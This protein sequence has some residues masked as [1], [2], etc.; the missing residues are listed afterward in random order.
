MMQLRVIGLSR[1]IACGVLYLE[2]REL[3]VKF[4]ELS[5]LQVY[6]NYILLTQCVCIVSTDHSTHKVNCICNLHLGTFQD[7]K[8]IGKRRFWQNSFSVVILEIKLNKYKACLLT[9]PRDENRE[10][11]CE[12]K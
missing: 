11:Q 1:V 9:M 2:S 7:V 3:K 12:T 8:G 6:I 4:C 5:I 10:Y